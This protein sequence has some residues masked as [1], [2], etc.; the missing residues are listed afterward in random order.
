MSTEAGIN[1]NG[2][3]G[4]STAEQWQRLIDYKLIEWGTNP[5]KLEDDGLDPPSVDTVRRAIM[6][7]Q[8]CK[9]AGLPAPTYVVP[10]PNGG[11]VFVRREKDVSEEFHFWDD[12]TVEYF[13][14]Q[15][16][17]LVARRPI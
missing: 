1:G 5:G 2:Q 7:A 9:N 17:H 8:Q 3:F 14:F 13:Y 10:D 12:G 15:D 6:F 4:I 16:T 11:I